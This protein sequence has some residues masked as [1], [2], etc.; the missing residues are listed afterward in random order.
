[1]VVAERLYDAIAQLTLK[2]AVSSHRAD[3]TILQCAKALAA[4]A[5]RLEVEP[6]D[7]LEAATL[8]LGHRLPYDPFVSG[9]QLDAIELRHQLE[10]ILEIEI[11]PKK[12]RTTLMASL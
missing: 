12:K 7:I 4:L 6:A 5:G 9:P 8:A 11:D 1:V 10:E 3:I 2:S